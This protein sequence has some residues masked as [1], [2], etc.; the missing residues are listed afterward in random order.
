[1]NRFRLPYHLAV[2]EGVFND[3]PGAM[4]DI[5]PRIRNPKRIL[6]AYFR[7]SWMR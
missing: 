7:G 5:F 2:D 3:I 4:S 6:R 1:M